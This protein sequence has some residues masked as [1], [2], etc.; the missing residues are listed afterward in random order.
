MGGKLGLLGAIQFTK[1]AS[2]A[3]EQHCLEQPTART[4]SVQGHA[5]FVSL[6]RN[7]N[8]CSF[9]TGKSAFHSFLEDAFTQLRPLFSASASKNSVI[10]I[11]GQQPAIRGCLFLILPAALNPAKRSS[12]FY[13][14]RGVCV[15][16]K[17]LRELSSLR[18]QRS[19]LNAGGRRLP[20]WMLIRDSS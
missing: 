6:S 17:F 19:A 15:P 7:W 16:D 3:V 5:L 8:F 10:P 18:L 9:G 2:C 11:E 4:R 12:S 13:L 1:E 14:R 20:S